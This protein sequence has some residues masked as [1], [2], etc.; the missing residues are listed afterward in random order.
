MEVT[1]SPRHASSRLSR[2]RPAGDPPR[3]VLPAPLGSV[4]Q[5]AAR[6][7]AAAAARGRR[8]ARRARG[9]PRPADAA[10][11]RRRERRGLLGLRW[12]SLDLPDHPARRRVRSDH[13]DAGRRP[14]RATPVV[15]RHRPHHLLV[16]LPRRSRLRLRVDPRDPGP[17]L[18]AAA[19]S[20][21]GLRLGAVRLRHLRQ[22]DRRRPQGAA[23]AVRHAG[24]VRRRGDDL[25]QGRRGDLHV[26]QGR[27][28]RAVPDGQ[29]RRQRQAAHLRARATTAARS[30][31]PT[32]RRSCGARRGRPAPSSPT[33][34]RSWPST[35]CGRPSSRSGWPTPTAAT[36]GR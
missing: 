23:Q 7:H 24:Q 18:P 22:H 20:Q 26:R 21:Q 29:G 17:G 31:R 33:T 32:A 19:R 30:S 13:G 12:R 5:A 9:A 35:W 15:D 8:P 10:H 2:R 27:R 25:R 11:R 34:R 28:P 14:G 16:L 1:Y 36:R 3:R 4:S 6:R